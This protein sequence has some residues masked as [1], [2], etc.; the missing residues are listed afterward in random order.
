MDESGAF[1]EQEKLPFHTDEYKINGYNVNVYSKDFHPK[2]E[3]S[4]DDAVLFLAGWSAG[5]SK[6]IE[7]LCQT[8]AD[9]G[10]KD[11]YAL[12]SIAE[13]RV[14]EDRIP[15]E[16]Q[17]VAKFIQEKGLE[18]VTI[19]G[20][21]EGGAKAINL[22]SDLQ[23][24]YPDVS[25]EGL[26]LLAPVGLYQQKPGEFALNFLK[27]GQGSIQDLKKEVKAH[28][29]YQQRYKD[30]QEWGYV[31]QEINAMPGSNRWVKALNYLFFKLKPQIADMAD[32]AQVLHR[33]KCP[34]VLVQG[35]YDTVS[36]PNK[37]VGEDNVSLVQEAD[38]EKRMNGYKERLKSLKENFFSSSQDV[39]MVVPRRMG[40]HA[41]VH[42][43]PEEVAKVS[44][45]L[46]QRMKRKLDSGFAEPSPIPQEAG[47]E[48]NLVPVTA[49]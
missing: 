17:A 30:Y 11:S 6:N 1:N 9:Q 19:A 45:Y 16:A 3:A 14:P 34:V 37:V 33:I 39:S 8:Y 21:S 27:Q 48:E 29:A 15:I 20:H 4:K 40:H 35:E 10:K 36:D 47:N 18:K 46:L 41:F 31:P 23:D 2:E 5:T 12:N 38:Y 32:E 13:K 42:F 44:F 43:R 22:V 28:P 7:L 49:S 26:L 25:V 24:N